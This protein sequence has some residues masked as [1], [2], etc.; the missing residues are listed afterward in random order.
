MEIKKDVDILIKEVAACNTLTAEEDFALTK[1]VQ[2][3]GT[4]CE[5]MKKL[6]EVY[7]RFVVSIA[8]QYLDKGLS[9]DEL[10]EA[11]KSGLEK[12]ALKYDHSRGFKF[13]AYA[14]WWIRQSMLVA[15]E[16]KE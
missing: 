11:G 7:D 5:E 12:A 1:A 10:I 3:K 14:V 13:I 8:K 9:L 15:I 16:S 2:D 6:H 4:D